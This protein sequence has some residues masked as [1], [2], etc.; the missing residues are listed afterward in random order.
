MSAAGPSP[1]IAVAASSSAG[2]APPPTWIGPMTPWPLYSGTFPPETPPRR[3]G[4]RADWPQARS[5]GLSPHRLMS[6]LA[7]LA[8]GRPDSAPP[9]LR[10]AKEASESLC[11]GDG[12]Y[13]GEDGSGSAPTVCA[14]ALPALVFSSATSSAFSS[15][16]AITRQPH[17]ASSLPAVVPPAAAYVPAP[18]STAAAEAALNAARLFFATPYGSRPV[19]SVAAG[20]PR[21]EPVRVLAPPEP[22]PD[23]EA[24]ALEAALAAAAGAGPKPTSAAGEGGGAAETTADRSERRS[25]DLGGR[26][27]TG[28]EAGW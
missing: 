9:A 14:R 24:T 13:P 18:P 4:T 7:A 8:A 15:V 28:P 22:E 12:C 10:V 11:R 19:D 16:S 3:G 2:S 5:R 25:G 23:F 20:A 1:L 21:R 6:D 26:A 27:A 17:A